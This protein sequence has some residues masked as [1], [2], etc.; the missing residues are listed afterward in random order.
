M[1]F[2]DIWEQAEVFTNLRD[3]ELLEGKCGV[4][5]FKQVCLGC[6][7]RAFGITHN[8][9]AEEPFCIYEPRA[10]VN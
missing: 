2:H 1:A 9:L 6:R 8:Y 10:P 3:P 5:E 4:C 7:A